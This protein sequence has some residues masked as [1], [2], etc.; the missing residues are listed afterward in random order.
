MDNI[1][2]DV[3]NITQP[4]FN[5]LDQLILKKSE[6]CIKCQACCKE[7]GIHTPYLYTDVVTAEFYT[8]RGFRVTDN[9]GYIFLHLSMSCPHLTPAGC[10]IYENRPAVCIEF[11]GRIHYDGHCAWS[12]LD[13]GGEDADV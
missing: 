9:D 7:V 1:N 6:L 4:I 5:N 8:A 12:E 11:D 10:D 13:N 2:D 3:N